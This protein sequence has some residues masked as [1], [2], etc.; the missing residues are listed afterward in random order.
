MSKLFWRYGLYTAWLIALASLL[1][2]LYFR[3]IGH[4]EPC[5]LCWYQRICVFPLTII[6]GIA[7]YR[8]FTGIM[9]YVLPQ[10][11]I[12]LVLACYQIAIQEIPGWYPIPM[13]GAGPSCSEKIDVG[14]GFITMPMLSATS[15]LV[16]SLLLIFAWCSG[17]HDAN[18]TSN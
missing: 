17:R 16:I 9:P 13:C 8:G 4:I 2:S 18:S 7:A 5:N 1:G 3:E 15:F 14:L 10:S 6:L 12:G 11:L